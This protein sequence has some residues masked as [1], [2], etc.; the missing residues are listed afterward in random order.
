VNG[1]IALFLPGGGVA[2]VMY[3]IGALAALE[4]SVDGLDINAFGLFLGAST[5]ATVAA[6]LAG[7][8]EV[9]R[10]YRAFLDPGDVYFPLE[11]KHI[12]KMDLGQWARA[13]GTLANAFREGISTAVARAAESST[14]DRWEEIARLYD[15]LPA[16]FF[17][18]ERYERFFADRLARRGIGNSFLTLRQELRVIAHDLDHGEPVVF[19]APGQNHVPLTRACTASMALPPFFSP[20]SIGGR[21]C[22]NAGAAQVRLLRELWKSD[23]RSVVIVNPMVPVRMLRE[24]GEAGERTSLREKGAMWVANQAHRIAFTALLAAEIDLMQRE[25]SLEVILL[26]PDPTDT[27]LFM[28]NPASFAARRVILEHSYRKTREKLA[29][30]SSERWERAAIGKPRPSLIPENVRPSVRRGF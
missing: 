29:T 24:N 14:S 6:A 30:W 18:L 10:I 21:Q 25:R 9:R 11:R 16:G 23:A 3:Q 7:G 26:E 20:I 2:G 5:G 28:Y 19:G 8:S 27:V 1:S 22:I 12:L 15:S 13:A 17:S 4:D